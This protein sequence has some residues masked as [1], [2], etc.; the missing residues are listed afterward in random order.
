[1]MDDLKHKEA[2]E[3]FISLGGKPTNENVRKVSDKFSIS[4]RTVWRWYKR[5]NWKA[6]VD[7]R[8]QEIAK[9]LQEKTDTNIIYEKAKLVKQTQDNLK[10]LQGVISTSIVKGADGKA[11][12]KFSIETIEDLVRILGVHDKQVR[13]LMD[14]L[15]AGITSG[16]IE[17]IKIVVQTEKGKELTEKL[18]KGD[19]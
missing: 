9:K 10:I 12:L 4:D 3:Y 7:I 17:E 6:Q 15:G 11:K 1:M 2:F 18:I 8:N 13:L 19:I 16:A 14:L 5:F